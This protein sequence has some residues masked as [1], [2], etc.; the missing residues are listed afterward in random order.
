MNKT[1]QRKEI[2]NLLDKMSHEEKQRGSDAICEQLMEIASLVIAN[3]IFAYLPLQNEVNLNPLIH[4][5]ID[6]SRTVG[7]PLC[8]WED[9]TMRAGLITSLQ[10]RDL[11]ETRHGLKEPLHKHPISADFIEIMLVPGMGFDRSGARLG[12]GGG[13]Y[14]RY[15]KTARPPIVVG[16]AFDEQILDEVHCDAHDQFMTAIVT[17][18]RTLLN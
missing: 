4:Q 14:D 17:P 15:L 3:T 16:V 1:N 6:E 11:I 5:W 8:S 2:A 18:T 13:F 12:R 10:S 7:V 9:H